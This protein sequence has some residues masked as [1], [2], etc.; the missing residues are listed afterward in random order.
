M[1]P[2]VAI[3]L[4]A[5]RQHNIVT[6]E[7]LLRAGLT[8]RH[9]GRRLENGLLVAVH[10]GVYTTAGA[11]PTLQGRALAACF[12][13]GSEAFASHET[14]LALLGLRPAPAGDVEIT[15]PEDVRIRLAGITA[16]RSYDVGPSQRTKIDGVPC[17]TGVRTLIDVAGALRPD[18]LESVLDDA[19]RRRI[20]GLKQLR[21]EAARE[22]FDN[23]AGIGTLRRLVTERTG[24]GISESE[25]ETRMLRVLRRA[26][27]P[28][29]VRQYAVRLGARRFRFDLAYP[30][31][32]IAIELDGLAPHYGKER[33]QRDHDRHNATELAGWVTLRFTWW[34]V[35]ERP[36]LVVAQVRAALQRAG[37]EHASTVAVLQ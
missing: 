29:P 12:A 27:L 21:R 28:V 6:R 11:V 33:W 26:K 8:R 19:I 7:Q 22:L 34:D 25:L 14:S 13:G 4:I 15:T 36:Y 18:V 37:I 23:R 30:E 24:I 17:G 9:I 10:P 2:D 16:H 35:T 20:V 32:R 31:L 1:R 3:L 5:A